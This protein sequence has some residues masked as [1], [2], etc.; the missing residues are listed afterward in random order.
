M[1][2]VRGKTVTVACAT[3]FLLAMAALTGS[4]SDAAERKLR[5]GNAFD[6]NLEGNPS[7][8]Y[9]WILNTS[10][11]S[12]LDAVKVDSRGYQ[13][14]TKRKRGNGVVV[15]APAP[16]VFRITC[17]KVGFAHLV[18]D[19]ITPVRKRSGT[20]HETWVHCE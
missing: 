12:G 9:V 6:F 15:G 11:S 16:F 19:Y 14:A 20:S 17:I 7:T 8:G 13:G 4:P 3:A 10:A 5:L 18:F 1:N 2:K